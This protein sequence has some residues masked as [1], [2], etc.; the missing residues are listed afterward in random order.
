TKNLGMRFV[1]IPI[2][3]TYEQVLKELETVFGRMEFG[4]TQENL[5]ARIRG[6]M[7]MAISNREGSLLLGTSN[8]S[9]LA[10]GYSTLYGDMIGGLMP[11][12]DLLK[13]EVV[14]LS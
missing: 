5:Q 9:E 6:M 12:G 3:R 13:G 2:L 10:V 11:I 8:K 1:Q 4:V 14:A 7:L